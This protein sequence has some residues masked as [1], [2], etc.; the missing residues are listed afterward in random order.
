MYRSAKTIESSRVG[1]ETLR[2][3]GSCSCS[4]SEEEAMSPHQRWHAAIV[5]FVLLADL[6]GF[7]VVVYAVGSLIVWLAR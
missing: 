1:H 5:A 3:A 6:L 2:Q 7:I 4:D